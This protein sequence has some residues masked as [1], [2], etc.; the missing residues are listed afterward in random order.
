M[1]ISNKVSNITPSLSRK[2]FNLAA[3]YNDVIDLTL[4]DP[5]I[6]P[7]PLIKDAAC[8]A[9]QLGH[10]RYSANAGLIKLRETIANDVAK[11]HGVSVDP[12]KEV[13]VTVGGMEAL[14][15]TISTLVDEGD[16]V[17][18]LAPYYVNYLQMV[19]LAGGVPVIV[20]SS[21]EDGFVPSLD[22]IMAVVNDNTVAIIIN[23]PCNPTGVV[24]PEGFLRGVA[25]LA[26][27]HGF[28]VVSDEVYRTL[29]FDNV[30]YF[31]IFSIDGMRNHTILIDS[32]SKRFAMTGYR[33][34]YAVAP[35]DIASAMSSLQEN[36]AACAP[37]PSQ[38]AAEAG[39][40]ELGADEQLEEIFSSRRDVLCSVLEK[41]SKI[42]FVK[43]Q[44]A[45]YVFANIGKTGLNGMD[46]AMELLKSKHVAVVPGI[47]YGK[48]D[49]YIRIAY[50][51]Q[52]NKLAEGARRITEFADSI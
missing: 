32:A 4:G 29:R 21:I 8:Q 51:V 34:G 37:L 22:K 9:I 7:N 27:E 17:I 6:Q 10:T 1:K 38:Y 25:A 47:T 31:S 20:D 26:V 19:K 48:Y 36:V 2:L 13:I 11:T 15:L 14:F 18:I 42:E 40:R 3:E 35:T 43:P 44:G 28:T 45:F 12:S 24:F 30:P 52:E 49:N 50:T 23:N 33:L 16:E 39:L 41:S 46:F 5:D